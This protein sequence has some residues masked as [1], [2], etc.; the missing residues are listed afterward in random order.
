[1][2]QIRKILKGEPVSSGIAV[3]K[4]YTYE[5]LELNTCK[6]AFAKGME[7][8]YLKQ[9][10]D[11]VVKAKEEIRTIYEKIARESTENAEI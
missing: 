2:D 5:P 4:A 8:E 1:M 3:A 7:R 9:F 11:T 10:K 6:I